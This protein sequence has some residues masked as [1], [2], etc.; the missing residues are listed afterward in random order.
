MQRIVLM[1][2][3][4]PR[5]R[6]VASQLHAVIGLAGIVAEAKPASSS[7]AVPTP[8]IAR[9]FAARDARERYWF[10][11]AA[12][13]HSDFGCPVHHVTWGGASAAETQGFLGNLAPERILLFGAS[14]IRGPILSE[15]EGRIINMH[16]GLSPYYRGSATNFWP[17]VDGLPECVGV[18]I[19]HAT[20]KVDAGRILAQTRPEGLAAN[21]TSHDIGCKAVIAGTHLLVNVA[22]RDAPL[23]AGKTQEDRGKLC[24]RADFDLAALHAMQKQMASRLIARYL[25]NKTERDA[26]YP[27][28][29][30]SE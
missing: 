4:S 13:S 8:E 7:A 10:A 20:A 6:W 3:S 25:A 5:H 16:L 11:E 28:A 9:Y 15:Y 24:R 29:S 12:A 17:L 19:H 18:T 23:P 22:A 30:I 21:D 1:T 2:S 27:I 26:R 14:I